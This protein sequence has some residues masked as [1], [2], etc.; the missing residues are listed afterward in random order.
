MYKKRRSRKFC[1]RGSNSDNVF[2][3]NEGERTKYL[4]PGAK[5]GLGVCELSPL[6]LSGDET[7]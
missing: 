6:Y 2:L 7:G 1:Q 4:S 3:D 5:G